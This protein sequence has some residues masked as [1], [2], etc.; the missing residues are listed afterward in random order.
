M[1]LA[2]RR[3]RIVLAVSVAALAAMTVAGAASIA[4]LYP[5][6][7]SRASF[8]ASVGA[9]PGLA[10][11]IGPPFDLTTVGGITAWRLG[12]TV[13]VLAA[14]IGLFTVVRHTRAEEE[15]GRLE[16]LG[17]GVVG[18]HAPLTAALLVAWGGGLALAVA[19]AA[20]LIGLVELPTEGSIALAVAL[21]SVCWTFAAIAAVAAQ[22][23]ESARTARG[24]AAAALGASY[25]ARAA[26]D[27]A[28]EG[29]LLWLS[30][31]SPIGWAQR[32]RPF[33]DERWWV[34][35]VSTAVVLVLVAIAY[36]LVSRRDLGAGLLPARLGAA[37]AG[38][39]LA[40]ALGLAWRLQR[41]ALLGWTVGFALTGASLGLV[42][43][44]VGD[45]LD[46]NAQ[47]RSFLAERG[48]AQGIV[49][50][51]LAS[52]V[53][54]V[55]IL[56]AAYAVQATLRLRSEERELRAEPILA[57]GVDRARWTLSHFVFAVVGSAIPLAAAGLGAG[58]VHGLRTGDVT[59]QVPRLLVAALVQLPAA[60]VLA[61]IALALFG[62]VPRWASASWALLAA[63]LVLAQLGQVLGLDERILDLSP[64]AHVPKLPGGELHA[65]P[66]VALTAVAAALVGA[67][68]V[69]F[70][71]RDVS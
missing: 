31:L 11:L 14:L 9:N 32:V 50:A 71:R 17:A 43:Q 26:G 25:V 67:G 46:D 49:D 2:L 44:G 22:L 8:A 20:G 60:W 35:G 51:Y 48:G 39:G 69:G 27:S 70:R 28:G 30:W 62:L 59:A 5:S 7:R 40:S 13:A 29:G 1:R 42:A 37:R 15:A 52:S 4:E 66:L 3:D 65:A 58:L 16:L 33:A 23:S 54:F 6:A 64:F 53:G 68:L 57:T 12:G 36:R 47:L 38:T 56:A 24:I 21:G 41:A 45:L 63:F 10:A 61:G 19:V 55:G 34:L 18:R